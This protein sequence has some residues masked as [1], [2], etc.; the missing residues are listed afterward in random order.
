VL[1]RAAANGQ[2]TTLGRV[3][4]ISFREE[5]WGTHEEVDLSAAL[6]S[7]VARVIVGV[8]YLKVSRG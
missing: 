2:N 8:A 6:G 5:V 4:E 1:E 3:S 7:R